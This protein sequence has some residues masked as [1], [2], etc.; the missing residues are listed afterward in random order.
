MTFSGTLADINTA[1]SG[2]TYRGNLNVSGTDTLTITTNNEGNNGTDPGTS[3][4]GTSE[5]DIDTVTITV[6]AVN[7]AP[8]PAGFD[9][10][11]TFTEDGAA[12]VLDNNASAHRRG[13]RRRQQLRRRRA[14]PAAPG[15][16]ERDR[17]VR[18]PA[19]P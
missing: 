7:D 6:N 16:G 3:G 10:T 1:L 15:R 5:E 14:D 4:D 2:L 11:P 17:R 12:V 9:N 8:Q 13:G 18:R 19:G